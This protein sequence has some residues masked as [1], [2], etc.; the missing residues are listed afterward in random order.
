MRGKVGRRILRFQLF[1]IKSRLKERM[2]FDWYATR[3]LIAGVF[4]GIGLLC[5][6]LNLSR[7]TFTFLKHAHQLDGGKMLSRKVERII[8]DNLPGQSGAQSSPLQAYLEDHV[9]TAHKQANEAIASDPRRMLKSMAIVVASAHSRTARGVIILCYNYAF[10]L[11]AQAFDLKRV[12]EKYHIVLEPSWSGYCTEDILCYALPGSRAVFVQAYEP[13]DRNFIEAIDGSLRT[14]SVSAN[15][16][17]DHRI[18]CPDERVEKDLDFIMVASW[19]NFKRH[20]QF[21]RALRTLRL[22]GHHLRGVCVGYPAGLTMNDIRTRA[23]WYGVDD[24]IMFRE[25]ISQEEIA[26]LMNRAKVNVVWSRREGVNRVIIEGMFC[27]VP[28][29]IPQGFNY[30]YRYPYINSETGRWSTDTTL[31]TDLL[32]MVRSKWPGSPSRWVRAN[33]TPQHAAKVVHQGIAEYCR[34]NRESC[35]EEVVPKTNGLHGQQY[36]DT[37]QESRFAADYS[38]LET[39]LNSRARLGLLSACTTKSTGV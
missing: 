10:P 30:G 17:V 1:L 11:F 2:Q 29:L 31:A 35:P 8:R 27:D 25:F 24:Q 32:A 38:Y 5:L 37:T 4:C 9:S 28:C 23:E 16:W 12:I 7:W 18:F 13:R 3:F 14:L 33:M 39:L 21:F 15:W 36:W 22:R 6:H 20:H 19:A 26:H 34:Q